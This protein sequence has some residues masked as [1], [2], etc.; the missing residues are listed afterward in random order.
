MIAASFFIGMAL[1]AAAFLLIR[2]DASR[3]VDKFGAAIALFTSWC[4]FGMLLMAGTYGLGLLIPGTTAAAVLVVRTTKFGNKL[5]A[6]ARYKLPAAIGAL[7]CSL[8]AWIG[9]LNMMEVLPNG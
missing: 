5:T 4:A 1:C 3:M 2:A 8:V 9:V 7:L 6:F